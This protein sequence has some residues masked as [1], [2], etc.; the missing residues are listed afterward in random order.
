MQITLADLKAHLRLDPDDT[1]EDEL[2]SAKIEAAEQW[3][4]SYI[5][6][7]LA[8]LGDTI[9]APVAE[10]VRQLAGHAYDNREGSDDVPLDTIRLLSPFRS[11]SF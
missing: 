3:V 8:D 6:T 9:P 10:A 1:S 4:A 5:G 11:W 2:L 7:P